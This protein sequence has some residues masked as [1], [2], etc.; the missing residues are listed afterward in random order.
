MERIGQSVNHT[1]QF[2]CKLLLTLGLAKFGL[3]EYARAPHP[4]SQDVHLPHVIVQPFRCSDARDARAIPFDPH[5]GGFETHTPAS[6]TVVVA[7]R[8]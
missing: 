5:C 6:I 7:L 3:V 1:H 2:F 8:K 4:S